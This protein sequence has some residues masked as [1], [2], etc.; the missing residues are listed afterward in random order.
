MTISAH[1]CCPSNLIHAN[2][3]FLT[4]ILSTRRR[5]N[6]KWNY[7][8]NANMHTPCILIQKYVSLWQPP[9]QIERYFIFSQNITL[10][11]FQHFFNMYRRFVV[12]QLLI[13]VKTFCR[14]V[15]RRGSVEM[16]DLF[17]FSQKICVW[18][19]LASWE[20]WFLV[21]LGLQTLNRERLRYFLMLSAVV[22][23]Y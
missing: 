13:W 12:E 23:L 22:M 17:F 10:F 18:L 21:F 3:D 1:F 8:L 4:I 20:V 2:F 14:H 15:E 5:V 19:S 9:L 6:L 16:N 7:F 11:L